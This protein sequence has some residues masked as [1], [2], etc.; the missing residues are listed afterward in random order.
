[1]TDN[2]HHLESAFNVLVLTV[3]C[4]VLSLTEH[5]TNEQH[6]DAAAAKLTRQVA[7]FCSANAEEIAASSFASIGGGGDTHQ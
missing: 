4:L 1:M 2:S 6:R 5:T 3:D 7:Q